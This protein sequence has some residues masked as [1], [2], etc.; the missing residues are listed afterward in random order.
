MGQ[1]FTIFIKMRVA[2]LYDMEY[3]GKGI[4][5]ECAMWILT[6]ISQS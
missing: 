3:N 4:P 5:W 6:I 2:V 1:V